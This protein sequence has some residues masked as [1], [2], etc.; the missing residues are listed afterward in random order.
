MSFSP[1][2]G[3]QLLLDTEDTGC[4]VYDGTQGALPTRK[5]STSGLTPSALYARRCFPNGV[6]EREGVQICFLSW[7]PVVLFLRLSQR[8]VRLLLR[9]HLVLVLALLIR[10]LQPGLSTSL[11]GLM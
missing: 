9:W 11:V 8:P 7:R 10:Q 5:G 2:P 6:C 3:R 1:A 4:C